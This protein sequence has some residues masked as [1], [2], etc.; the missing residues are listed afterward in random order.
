MALPPLIRTPFGQHPPDT[1]LAFQHW[2]NTEQG[3]ALVASERRILSEVLPRV[4]GQRALQ[5]GL[6]EQPR[7]LDDCA[8]PC[9]WYMGRRAGLGNDAVALPAALPLGKRSLDLVLLHHS[10]DF[11]DHPH[12]V[13][14]E[15]VSALQPGGWLVVVGFNPFSLWGI[16]RMF[17]VASARVPWSARFLRPIRLSDWLNLL[18]CQV[19]GLESGFFAPPGQ[20][21]ARGQFQ[22]LEA[23]GRRL[24]RQR[25]AFYVLVARKRAV[26][27][28]PLKPRLGLPEQ[29]PGQVAVP[30]VGAGRRRHAGRDGGSA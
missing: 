15:A 22:W 29:Q 10:L 16:T 8:M 12:K 30:I 26:I 17:R 20:R 3:R 14:R 24:W 5:I 1:D 21:G 11:E 19:E 25:G 2:L 4:P 23:L 7:L 6:G 13:L 9:R 27:M 18:S 28:R